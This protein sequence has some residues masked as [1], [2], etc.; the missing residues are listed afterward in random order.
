VRAAT[1]ALA[2]WCVCSGTAAAQRPIGELVP[3][4]VI[5]VGKTAD[6]VAVTADAVWVGGT[7][8]F[9]V[10]RI[11]PKTNERVASVAL[12]GEPCA[13]LAIGFGSLW[14]PLCTEAPSL[15]RIDLAAN[16]LTATFAVGPA[17]PEG[18]IT[19]G[20]GNVWLV[21]DRSG[22]LAR[23]DPVTGAIR[24][25]VKVPAGSYNPLFSDGEI[26]VTRAE[27]AEVTALNAST[28]SL[29]ASVGTGPNP[30]FLTAAAGAIWTL[31][32]GDGTLTRIDAQSHR[33]T[34]TIALGTP[35]H[36]GDL[37]A[38][39]GMVWTTM[40]KTPLS[41]VDT[42]NLVLQCQW[43]GP[44]GDSLGIGHD[45]IWLTDYHGGTISRIPLKDALAACNR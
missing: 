3:A 4:A 1:A 10:H 19:T 32:Q 13:G 23:I 28:G 42:K 6:W 20:A 30:R 11:D 8:P 39:G 16:R 27:S 15:A 5:Q 33:A 24:Q 44:G 26:W 17:A 41:A 7:G 14:V 9:A 43:T 2:L 25:T 29:I 36:G 37:G 21:T 45:A 31:N 35:G 38:G 22:S 12:A 18:G 34:T 40:P